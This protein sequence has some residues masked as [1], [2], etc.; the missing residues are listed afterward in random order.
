MGSLGAASFI[1]YG[2]RGSVLSAETIT[3]LKRVSLISAVAVIL[4][5]IYLPV[6]ISGLGSGVS[7][8][9]ESGQLLSGSYELTLVARGVLSI[10][11]AGLIYYGVGKAV[12]TKLMLLQSPL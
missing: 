11:G 10:F 12:T 8:A 7:A 9:Q 2:A 5:L 4:P 3:L 6:F 1:A